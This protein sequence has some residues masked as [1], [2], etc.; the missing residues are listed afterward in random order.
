M[1]EKLGVL[2]ANR[3]SDASLPSSTTFVRQTLESMIAWKYTKGSCLAAYWSLAAACSVLSGAPMGG[4]PQVADSR[5]GSFPMSSMYPFHVRW[6][7][8]S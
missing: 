1:N 5:R 2:S 6:L 7:A 4:W 8:V 3:R